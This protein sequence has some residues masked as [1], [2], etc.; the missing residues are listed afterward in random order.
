MCR[1]KNAQLS[2]ALQAQSESRAQH[3]TFHNLLNRSNEPFSVV[4]EYFGH[5]MFNKI[6]F[7]DESDDVSQ[8]VRSFIYKL[9]FFLL[10]LLFFNN[11]SNL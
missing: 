1:A 8:E 9:P 6:F 3:E 4:A 11:I 10:N 2:D 5:G 7:V